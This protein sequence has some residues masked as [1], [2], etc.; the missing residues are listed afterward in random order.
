MSQRSVKTDTRRVEPSTMAFHISKIAQ[1]L[2]ALRNQFRNQVL[3]GVA[4]T[5]TT[6]S[7]QASGAAGATVWNINHS[8]IV[9]TVAGVTQ[10]FVAA[11][12]YNIH[13]G[14]VYTGLIS[15]T[16]AI[17][18]LV[19]VNTAG[20]ITLD[21]VNGTAATTDSQVAPTD[22]EIQTAVGADQ[23]WVKIAELTINRTADTTV[24][25]SEDNSKRPLVG[26]TEDTGFGDWS[27]IADG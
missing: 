2:E 5:P 16:S 18:A 14:S 23:S 6:G 21:T 17:V 4:S 15:G 1:D 24:T 26:I 22:A 9:V 19:A 3:E 11:A 27:D 10:H 7:T 12:D 13:T 8:Q 20:T 25:Q